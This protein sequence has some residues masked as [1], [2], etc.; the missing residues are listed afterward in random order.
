MVRTKVSWIL[1]RFDFEVATGYNENF[2]TTSI[3]GEERNSRMLQDSTSISC[4]DIYNSLRD[5]ISQLFGPVGYG[6]ST[7]I[8]VRLYDAVARRAMIRTPMVCT[9]MVRSSL[10]FMTL[11]KGMQVVTC[12]VSVNRSIR[13]AKIATIRHLCK[14]IHLQH[15][16][17]S[18]NSGTK[19][20]V[21]NKSDLL[22]SDHSVGNT[23]Y[24]QRLNMVR[25]L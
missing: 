19:K 3:G 24:V 25:D 2:N 1:V 20:M 4:K 14:N 13:T 15:K 5:V 7:T 22:S 8:E 11:L 21:R 12:V 18:K 16:Q 23:H 17:Q 10:T 6:Q 9:D